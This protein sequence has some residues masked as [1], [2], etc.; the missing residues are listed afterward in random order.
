MKKPDMILFDYGGTLLCEPE[1]DMLRGEQ[2]VFEHVISNPHNYSPDILC[3]WEKSY[4]QS[5]QS[6][7]D[8]GAEPTEI[9]MLRLKYEL[10]GIQLNIPYEEAELI[11]W[12]HTAPMTEQCLHPNIKDTL[13][14]LHENGIRTGVVSNIGWTGAALKRRINILLPDHHFEF[15]LASSDYGLRKPDARL[16]QVALE[17]AKLSPE[18]VWFCGDTY[19]KDIDGANSAGLT[20]VYYQG[21]AEGSAERPPVMT[22]FCKASYIISD[23]KELVS[24]LASKPISRSEYRQKSVIRENERKT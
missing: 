6:V 21:I 22:D 19:D 16:F 2:A 1:W 10:H 15:I 4:F 18:M 9:Q 8:L 17:K 12:D 7:R 24:I 5:M 14:Y 23:W 3:A 20:T 11:F 13:K